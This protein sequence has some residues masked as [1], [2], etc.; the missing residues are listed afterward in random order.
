MNDFIT[1]ISTA[2][3][4]EERPHNTLEDIFGPDFPHDNTQL[5]SGECRLCG[6]KIYG[7]PDSQ[8]P[9]CGTV[10]NPTNEII[11]TQPD[12][13]TVDKMLARFNKQWEATAAACIFR[14]EELEGAAM[15]LRERA[16]RLRQAQELTAEVRG[17][18]QFEINARNRAASLALVNPRRE[19]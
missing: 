15:D 11:E 10:N 12:T 6:C 1:K 16:T 7:S 2:I 3:R 14:A 9:K 8:C 5:T 18:V 19:E 17:A 13:P 4:S